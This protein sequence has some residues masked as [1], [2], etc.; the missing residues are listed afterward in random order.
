MFEPRGYLRYTLASLVDVRPTATYSEKY[1][2]ICKQIPHNKH[3]THDATASVPLYVVIS[4]R[5]DMCIVVRQ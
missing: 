5:Y 4:L 3:A 2:Y 1:C